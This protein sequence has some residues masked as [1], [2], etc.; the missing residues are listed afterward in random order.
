[1]AGLLGNF[2]AALSQ[3][4]TG[5]AA[6][7]APVIPGASD[8]FSII[9]QLQMNGGVTPFSAA[10]N[11]ATAEAP[12]L[13]WLGQRVNARVNPRIA[14]TDGHRAALKTV[15]GAGNRV[16]VD[17]QQAL[18]LPFTW[19]EKEREAA[20]KRVSQAVGQPVTSFEQFNSIWSS[21]VKTAQMSWAATQGGKNGSPLTVWDV[22]DL[23]KREGSKYGYGAA[24]TTTVSHSSSVEKLSDG[25]TWSILKSA[26]TN[27]MGR[28]P[29]N[30]ELRRFASKA[31]Q[32]AARNPTRTRTVTTTGPGGST[33]RSTTKQGASAGDYQ[34]A[35]ENMANANPETGAYQ[36]ATTY[37]DAF[38]KG[39]GAMV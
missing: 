16:A 32:I 35:A 13:V 31:N 24:P 14:D 6:G 22:F 5:L 4:G 38:L 29:T 34:L 26:L 30:S 23:A 17:P 9:K 18:Y 11:I 21:A 25:S 15:N 36:A 12:P 28:A 10:P 2:F 20:Y 37:Y 27:S 1:M 19:G 3:M 8:P 33:S 7:S 39:I